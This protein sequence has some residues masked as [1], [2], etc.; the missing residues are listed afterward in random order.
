MTLK[1]SDGGVRLLLQF[2]Q[3]DLSR[4]VADEG[5]LRLVIVSEQGVRAEMHSTCYYTADRC[6]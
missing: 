3:R 1:R 5:V 4:V 2:Q 6:A